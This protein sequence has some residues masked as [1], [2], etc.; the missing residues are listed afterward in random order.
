MEKHLPKWEGDREGPQETMLELGSEGQKHEVEWMEGLG[1][2][3][4]LPG[5]GE[6]MSE[7]WELE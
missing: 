2:S 5:K 3:K 1:G 6:S 4:F 7:A